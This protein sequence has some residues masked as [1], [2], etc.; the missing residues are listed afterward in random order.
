MSHR[1][2]SQRKPRFWGTPDE[3]NVW[4]ALND[5]GVDMINTDDLPGLRKFLLQQDAPSNIVPEK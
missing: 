4:K 3:A 2:T 5:A 1:N